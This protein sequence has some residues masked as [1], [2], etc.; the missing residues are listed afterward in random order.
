MHTSLRVIGEPSFP[1]KGHAHENRHG[2]RV[3]ATEDALG[4]I[5]LALGRLSTTLFFRRW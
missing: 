4:I 2:Q 1:G 3:L 5:V